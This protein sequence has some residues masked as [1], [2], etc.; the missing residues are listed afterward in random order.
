MV[1]HEQVKAKRRGEARRVKTREPPKGGPEPQPAAQVPTP[2][3]HRRNPDR[4]PECDKSLLEPTEGEGQLLMEVDILNPQRRWSFAVNA[5]EVEQMANLAVLEAIRVA[6]SHENPG[7]EI[8][9][10]I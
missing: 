9:A 5:S 7:M 10:I 4:I 1:F 2:D 8:G 3:S 6:H